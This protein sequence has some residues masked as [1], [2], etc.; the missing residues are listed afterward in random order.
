[1][2]F[3]A[4]D[5]AAGK[6]AKCKA[7]GEPII[8]PAPS[9]PEP[10]PVE[11]P[12]VPSA[13]AIVVLPKPEILPPVPVPVPIPPPA[14]VVHEWPQYAAPPQSQYVACAFCGEDV[15]AH[16][17][18]CKHCGETLD[19]ALRAAE[20]AKREVRES[21]RTRPVSVRQSTQVNVHVKAPFNHV[22]HLVLDV[23][24]CGMWIPV[25]LLCWMAH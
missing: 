8:V 24:T 15:L 10:A 21:R 25:H 22:L 1:M 18:K 5:N 9:T 6:K 19:V 7:C 12:P 23:L 3:T 11:A 17:R 2:K 20:E 13:A 16:A 14:P 4:P